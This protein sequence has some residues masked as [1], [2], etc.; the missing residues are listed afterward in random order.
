MLSF[1]P[2]RAELRSCALRF[3][4]CFT[5]PLPTFSTHAAFSCLVLFRSGLPVTQ[6]LKVLQKADRDKLLLESALRDERRRNVIV[7]E[8]AN[9]TREVG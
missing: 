4:H 3:V 5:P 1:L 6:R 7:Q 9:L 8:D 2:P